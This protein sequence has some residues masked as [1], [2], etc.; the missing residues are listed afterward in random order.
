MPMS[1]NEKAT[2]EY[3]K[4][5]W[6]LH[7]VTFRLYTLIRHSRRLEVG[8]EVFCERRI[9]YGSNGSRTAN[10]VKWI[11][12]LNFRAKISAKK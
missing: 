8:W 4:S 9:A 5:L 12:G 11:L 6:S 7:I 10:S 3:S 2:K 1:Q